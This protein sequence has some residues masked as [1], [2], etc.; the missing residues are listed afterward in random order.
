MTRSAT[1]SLT[2]GMTAAPATVSPAP[3][4][5]G[6]QQASRPGTVSPDDQEFSL[7]HQQVLTGPR[8]SAAGPSFHHTQVSRLGSM[9]WRAVPQDPEKAQESRAPLLAASLFHSVKSAPWFILS[10]QSHS[11]QLRVSRICT[12]LL[13]VSFLFSFFFSFFPVLGVEKP[14]TAGTG[15]LGA[16][17][18]GGPSHSGEY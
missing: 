1:C 2:T 11:H 16:P 17:G 10:H 5:H 13:P 7:H 8:A 18:R 12:T 9:A 14:K 3:G 15:V 6:N 4:T